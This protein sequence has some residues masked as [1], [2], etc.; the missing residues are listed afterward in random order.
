MKSLEII[1]DSECV[2]II[3]YS[4]SFI[5][6]SSPT[7][8]R[9]PMLSGKIRLTSTKPL[10]AIKDLS[11]EFIGTIRVDPPSHSFLQRKHQVPY[12]GEKIPSR[13]LPH[14]IDNNSVTSAIYPSYSKRKIIEKRSVL[15]RHIN[16]VNQSPNHLLSNMFSTGEDEAS[17]KLEIEAPIAVD[18]NTAIKVPV[19]SDA[20]LTESTPLIPT[21]Y[22]SAVNASEGFAPGTHEFPFSLR[23]PA[24]L[25]ATLNAPRAR[26]EYMLTATLRRKGLSGDIVK[27]C[28]V[29][30]VRMPANHQAVSSLYQQIPFVENFLL[31][32][33]HTLKLILQRPAFFRSTETHAKEDDSDE[34]DTLQFIIQ[35]QILMP[36]FVSEI[37]EINC[38]LRE[39]YRYGDT[40]ELRSQEQ[41]VFSKRSKSEERKKSTSIA[42]SQRRSSVISFKEQESEAQENVARVM[43]CIDTDIVGVSDICVFE[44]ELEAPRSPRSVR[45]GKNCGAPD[46]SDTSYGSQRTEFLPDRV[47]DGDMFQQKASYVSSVLRPSQSFN[48]VNK[49]PLLQSYTPPPIIR[50]YSNVHFNIPIQRLLVDVQEPELEIMHVL[51][52]QVKVKGARSLNLGH[53]ISRTNSSSREF[54]SG[55]GT[56]RRG[57]SD[58]SG[59]KSIGTGTASEDESV[60]DGTRVIDFHVALP[61]YSNYVEPKHTMTESE[62]PA[63][64]VA[65]ATSESFFTSGWKSFRSRALSI[66]SQLSRSSAHHSSEPSDSVNSSNEA[67]GSSSER[68]S[69]RF[70]SRSKRNRGPSTHQ[71]DPGEASKQEEFPQGKKDNQKSRSRTKTSTSLQSDSS[72]LSSTLSTLTQNSY[73]GSRSR[74]SSHPQNPGNIVFVNEQ[75]L[76]LQSL[77]NPTYPAFES[78]VVPVIKPELNVGEEDVIQ[79]IVEEEEK[80]R[81]RKTSA[82]KKEKPIEE[83]PA[84][85]P[86][87]DELDYSSLTFEEI[88]ALVSRLVTESTSD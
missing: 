36:Q 77:Y 88:N 61:V 74:S 47:V 4:S 43:E 72:I 70:R 42:K 78:S 59:T 16:Y 20:L 45:N 25:P 26:I 9:I 49:T 85:P 34:L 40:K 56:R 30:V 63:S 32:N 66:S 24:N 15:W 13:L 23:L 38:H 6:A 75:Q 79:K 71:E 14:P 37:L 50:T 82:K 53:K 11:M 33:E 55:F 35:P 17:Q 57:F 1:L 67:G 87:L 44:N 19:S 7:S 69:W 58:S 31:D 18:L 52:I 3:D 22:L 86:N 48:S 29:V 5:P 51:R 27:R 65:T 12:D 8:D 84:L 28:R 64:E 68:R 39:W 46:S 60:E 76:Q 21:S 81:S 73:A 62:T 54:L 83:A 2:E 10:T 41:Q 80:K